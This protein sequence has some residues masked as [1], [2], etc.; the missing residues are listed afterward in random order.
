MKCNFYVTFKFNERRDALVP[1]TASTYPPADRQ[2]FMLKINADIPETVLVP[3]VTVVLGDAMAW[4]RQELE[5]TEAELGAM[6]S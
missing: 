4:A 2:A 1:V 6:K 3:E 5:Q